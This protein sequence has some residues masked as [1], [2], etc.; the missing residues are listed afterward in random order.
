MDESDVFN[1]TYDFGDEFFNFITKNDYK[2]KKSVDM[3][4]KGEHEWKNSKV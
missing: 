4:S 3:I 1:M 2:K